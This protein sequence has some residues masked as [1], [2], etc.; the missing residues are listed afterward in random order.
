MK[1]EFIPYT[2]NLP[3]P[4]AIKKPSILFADPTPIFHQLIRNEPELSLTGGK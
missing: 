4:P 3:A 2:S 1:I